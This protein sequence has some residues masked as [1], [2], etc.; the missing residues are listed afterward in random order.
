MANN[1]KTDN[2]RSTTEHQNVYYPKKYLAK[3]ATLSLKCIAV[4]F[5]CY[6][7]TFPFSFLLPRNCCLAH[8]HAQLEYYN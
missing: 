4:C 8:F 2:Q 1:N 3:I 5:F 6:L 7:C